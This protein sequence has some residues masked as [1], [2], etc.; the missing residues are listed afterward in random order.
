MRKKSSFEFFEFE[1]DKIIFDK[2]KKN[3]KNL[4]CIEFDND[5]DSST[6]CIK[7]AI[8]FNYKNL[9]TRLYL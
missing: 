9:L 6:D 3:L 5:I 2:N 1:E 7:E 8:W 4:H